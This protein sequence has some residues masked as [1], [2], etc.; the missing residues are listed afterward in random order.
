MGADPAAEGFEALPR[1]HRQ[2]RGIEGAP[3]VFDRVHAG[4]EPGGQRRVVDRVHP[5]LGVRHP[6]DRPV[7]P[8][9]IDDRRSV[10]V[11]HRL[12]PDREP[13]EAGVRTAGPD[14]GPST[15]TAQSLPRQ[16]RDR[17]PLTGHGLDG[18]PPHLGHPADDGLRSRRHPSRCL[19][20]LDH[21]VS[22][23]IRWAQGC[24]PS[25]DRGNQNPGSMPSGGGAS[26]CDRKS[27]EGPASCRW[28]PRK[29][30]EGGIA[31]FYLN[32]GERR[33]APPGRRRPRR[34]SGRDR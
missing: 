31:G 34:T 32:R 27:F 25:P 23:K 13:G 21:G 33:E 24:Y 2:R 16:V 20:G 19:L 30:D 6:H 29:A 7:G 11:Q 9:G 18:V 28:M 15:V 8:V 12:L 14:E 5:F 17:D 3:I 1:D 4:A 10:V 22:L 26:G